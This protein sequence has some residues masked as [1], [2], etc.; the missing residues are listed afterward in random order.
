MPFEEI[1]NS[2][3]GQMNIFRKGGKV[4]KESE[5]RDESA[6]NIDREGFGV[7]ELGLVAIC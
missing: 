5:A 4:R 2:Y 1:E 3:E 6:V 7:G